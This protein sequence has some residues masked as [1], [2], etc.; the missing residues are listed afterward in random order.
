MTFKKIMTKTT[1]AITFLAMTLLMMPATSGTAYANHTI[2]VSPSG[3]ATV[4]FNDNC[5]AFIADSLSF[6]DADTDAATKTVNGISGHLATYASGAE[7]A[8]SDA[9]GANANG[10]IGFTQD[11]NFHPIGGAVG[12]GSL[13]DN[14]FNDAGWG[15][16][17][18]EPVVY[19]NWKAGEPNDSGVEDYAE[20]NDVGL[21]WNDIAVGPQ[22]GYYVEFEDACPDLEVCNED[23]PLAGSICK[24][25]FIDDDSGNGI[26]S[27]GEPVTYTFF[28]NAI[29]NDIVKW[30]GVVIKD[31]FGGDLAVGDVGAVLT[32]WDHAQLDVFNFEDNLVCDLNQTGKA[33]KEHLTCDVAADGNLDPAESAA[34]G[35]TAETDWNF[36]QSKKF[37]RTS[38]AQG[39]G[40]YTSCGVHEP[41]SGATIVYFLDAELT[42]G[43]HELSTAAFTVDVF[44]SD[45]LSESDCD[46]DLVFDDVDECP[47]EGTEVSGT[48]DG[49]GCPNGD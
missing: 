2:T 6:G 36:G 9:S 44:Q 13:S 30:F 17:T 34:M 15:W 48:V 49:V 28:I 23:G 1:F 19:T 4:A 42:D 11:T 25:V 18:G 47:F 39:T 29:N 22:P 43:P 21:Q 10:W 16:V 33:N 37:M 12:D 8:A 5:Y 20:N 3:E 32:D 26:I 7:E 35:V 24:S 38:G 40:E 27:I 45:T 14:I 46:G 41:N 31:N